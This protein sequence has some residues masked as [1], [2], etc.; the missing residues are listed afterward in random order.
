MRPRHAHAQPDQ[1]GDHQQQDEAGGGP[2]V[3]GRR[4]DQLPGLAVVGGGR[5]GPA[6]EEVGDPVR[7]PGGERDG[8]TEPRAGDQRAREPLQERAPRP[9]RQD[10]PA[11]DEHQQDLHGEE[12]GDGAAEDRQP[13]AGRPRVALEAGVREDETGQ[14]D[15]GV[16][17]PARER[18]RPAGRA[19][20]VHDGAQGHREEPQQ[21]DH[22]GD[23]GQDVAERV[24][25]VRDEHAQQH[26]VEGAERDRD[27]QRPEPADEGP[28]VPEA[29]VCQPVAVAVGGDRVR[30][31]PGP[32]PPAQ[33]PQERDRQDGDQGG[34]GEPAAGRGERALGEHRQVSAVLQAAGQ[35]RALPA[36]EVHRDLDERQ[37]ERR[38]HGQRE[39]AGQRPDH[40]P[41]PGADVRP[42]PDGHVGEHEGQ[43]EQ[44]ERAGGGT[45]GE[46]APA[47]RLQGHAAGAGD[48]AVLRAGAEE[49]GVGVARD[50]PQQRAVQDVLRRGP[51]DA[52]H[53][54]L[55][56]HGLWL[57]DRRRL[58]HPPCWCFRRYAARRPFS[59]SG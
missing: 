58:R 16:A 25:V 56:D 48:R 38:G 37:D 57:S 21:Q 51:R 26:R 30:L 2:L 5:L 59:Y 53:T 1:R 46:V 9:G 54:Q 49:P 4:L 3:R 20:A 6:V 36:Q 28:A 27:V 14:H 47:V 13:V 42:Q 55:S 23:A 7:H 11:E 39:D 8:D 19:V 10:H 52:V 35:R 31:V 44:P 12:H 24:P 45:G 41:W 17:E 18:L 43:Q 34:D 40:G 15:G 29:R 32:G 33:E 22:G 50:P